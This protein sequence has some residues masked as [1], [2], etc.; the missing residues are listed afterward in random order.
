VTAARIEPACLELGTR[1]DYREDRA[2]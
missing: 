1:I 2:E